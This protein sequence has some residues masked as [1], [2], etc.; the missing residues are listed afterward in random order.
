MSDKLLNN[1]EDLPFDI[2]FPY[3]VQL[4]LSYFLNFCIDQIKDGKFFPGK[5]GQS[6]LEQIESA[7]VLFEP[8][9]D[10]AL[11]VEH[12]EMLDILFTVVFPVGAQN[13]HFS[14]ALGPFS[15]EP[16]YATERFM[17]LMPQ[18][19]N[20]KIS[21]NIVGQ[22]IGK[23]KL[24][25]ACLSILNQIYKKDIH[26][27][28]PLIFTIRDGETGLIRYFKM[29]H[30][31]RFYKVIPKKDVEPLDEKVL[32]HLLNNPLDADELVKYLKPENYIFTGLLIIDFVDITGQESISAIKNDLLEKNALL[33]QDTFDTIQ[34]NVRALFG[35]KDITLGVAM[36][37]KHKKALTYRS[38]ATWKSIVLDAM[39]ESECGDYQN[40]VYGLLETKPMHVVEDLKKLDNITPIE[41]KLI[42]EGVENIA[43]ASLKYE[44][45]FLG[46]LELSSEV[47]GDI[48]I[49]NAARLLDILPMFC[50][51][52]QRVNDEYEN[53]VR[54]II[55][56]RCTSIHPTVE[57]KFMEE[58]M[59]IWDMQSNGEKTEFKDVTFKDVYPLYGMVDVR[60]SS[61][62]RNEAIRDDLM[63][64]LSM[65]K[66]VVNNIL[67]DK[68]MPILDELLFRIGK[69]ELMLQDGL[70]AGEESDITAF[71][72]KEVNPLLNHFKITNPDL[73]IVISDYYDQLNT[74][75]GIV[76]N[77]RKAFEDTITIINDTISL[78][79]LEAEEKAQ[80][81]FPH[82][83]E[84]Y[85]SDGVEYNLY[86]GSSMVKGQQ[87]DPVYLK[88]FRLW[89]LLN[90][91]EIANRINDIKD[92]FPMD[93]EVTFMVLV[94]SDTLSIRF[95]QE[96]KKFDVDGAY[97]MRYEI[98]KKRID[99]A[100]I[101]GTNERLTQPNKLAIVFTNDREKE[102]YI[103]YIE[104]LQSIGYLNGTH[105]LHELEDLPGAYGLKAIRSDIAFNHLDRNLDSDVINSLIETIEK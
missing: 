3:D 77:R 73:N 31:E 34:D 56:E 14:A 60:G 100:Y 65:V 72:K 62:A 26:F 51:A 42:S 68:P 48:N 93:L 50:L 44:E 69:K 101:K 47:P 17:E 43:I 4:D 64:N 33:K 82:Y 79:L 46:F 57:W 39:D 40:S 49:V 105:S 5:I 7:E 22:D 2:S 88:N 59:K 9:K 38:K 74:D 70:H 21:N 92:L 19:Q 75:F 41:Q 63:E 58:G 18:N 27:N 97:N 52:I 30:D 85:K 54:A 96:E 12:K 35:L 104:Y 90:L 78:F 13:N 99:K 37:N 76:Y 11:L 67:K 23:G 71:L 87:F 20:T 94:H 29:D 53:E 103:E 102:E 83:F 28:R 86:I 16:I 98:I 32:Q 1:I 8:I 80:E 81:I 15:F 91:C 89:Q 10:T 84:K 55:Q 66:G 45:E 61:K 25:K 95:R 36:F 24:V 6:L